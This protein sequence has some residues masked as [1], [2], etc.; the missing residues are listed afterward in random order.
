MAVG[1]VAEGVPPVL[2]E[3]PEDVAVTLGAATHDEKGGRDTLRKRQRPS[4]R[5][6][7]PGPSPWLRRGRRRR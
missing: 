2:L 6:C 5:A 1:A 3:R 7:G 4:L